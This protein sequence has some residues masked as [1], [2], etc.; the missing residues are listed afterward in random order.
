MGLGRGWGYQTIQMVFSNQ[1]HLPRSCS[2]PGLARHRQASAMSLDS[3]L[4]YFCYVCEDTDRLLTMVP[5]CLKA[6]NDPG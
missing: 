6:D 1:A 3:K 5:V 2:I 4:N